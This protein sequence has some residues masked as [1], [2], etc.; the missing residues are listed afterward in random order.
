MGILSYMPECQ[1]PTCLQ[2]KQSTLILTVHNKSVP[3][4]MRLKLWLYREQNGEL[5]MEFQKTQCGI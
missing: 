3:H 1:L 4:I 5:D 2:L